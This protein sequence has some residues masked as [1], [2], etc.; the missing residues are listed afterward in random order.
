MMA[1][2]CYQCGAPAAVDL[3]PWPPTC[4]TCWDALEQDIAEHDRLIDEGQRIVA[5]LS[6]WEKTLLFDKIRAWTKR[7]DGRRD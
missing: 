4:R 1:S 5:P 3:P 2:S 7:K 6:A